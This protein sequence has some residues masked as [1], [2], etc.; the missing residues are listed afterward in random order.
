MRVIKIRF[1]ILIMILSLT[2][3]SSA[4][5]YFDI[6]SDINIVNNT[7]AFVEI[8]YEPEYINNIIAKYS[9]VELSKT[10]YPQ[11]TVRAIPVYLPS[12]LNN[13]VEI[14]D[15]RYT[16]IRNIEIQPIP[17]L[18]R[19]KD[20]IPD[21]KFEKNEKIYNTNSFYPVEFASFE[22]RGIFRNKNLGYIKIYP[23]TYNPVTK[24]ARKITKITVRLTFGSPPVFSSRKNTKEEL[25]I[26]HGSAINYQNALNWSTDDFIDYPKSTLQSSVLATGDFYQFDIK[27]TG[28]YKID[29]TLL[30]NAGIN[31]D[32][33]EPSTI[34][35]FNNG[36]RELPYNNSIPPPEDLIENRIFVQTNQVGKFDYLLFYG[37]SI[38]E[39][40]YD[41]V[42]KKF[43]NYY[44]HYTN[45][46]IYWL[47]FN[48]SSGKRMQVINSPNVAGIQPLYYFYDKFFEKPEILNLG[49][50]GTLWLSQN[51]SYNEGFTFTKQL[52]GYI[53]GSDIRLLLRFGNSSS[54]S[55]YS[56]LKDDNSS[57]LKFY[58]VYPVSGD[59]SHFRSYLV[60]EYYALNSG[61]SSI[62]LKLSLPAQY[63]QPNVK[64][65]YDFYEIH[66]RRSFNSVQ[67]N[68][69][70]FTSPDTNTTVEYVVSPYTASGIKVF[71]VTDNYNVS[72]INPISFSGGVLR[73][74]DNIEYN[75]PQR[76][77]SVS[78]ENYKT[79]NLTPGKIPNQ[80]LRGITQGASYIIITPTEFISAANR[81]KAYRETPG[82][83]K[84]NTL[85][86]DVNQIY[87]EFSCGVLD[88]VAIRN[89]IKHAYINWQEPPVYILFFGDGSYDFKNIYNFSV[90]NY[91]PTV[92]RSTEDINEIYSYPSDDFL[93]DINENNNEPEPAV[94]DFATGRLCINSINE[95]NI[96]VD[97]IIDYENS[98]TN[99]SWKKKLMYVA[100]DGWTTSSPNGEEGSMHTDQ[101]EVIAEIFTPKDFEKEK[102]YIVTYPTVITPQGRR[103]PGANV[104]IIKGW[105]DGRLVINYVGHGSTDLWAHEHVFVRD[106]SIP[107][108][109]NKNK[110]PLLTIASCDLSRWDDPFLISAGE[111]LVS[112]KDKGAISVVS[113]VRPVYSAPN[114]I[115]N[116]KLWEI[117]MFRKDTLNLPIRFG[118]AMYL[119]KNLIPNFSHN[120]A[121]FCLIGEPALRISIPQFF[122]RIDS[123]N[124]TP[125]T[126]TAYIKALQ[127][128]KISGSILRPDST[129]WSDFNGEMD[130]KV[131]D[132]DKKIDIID[133]SVHFI[134]TLDGGKIFSGKTNISNGKWHIEFIV[135]KDISYGSGSGKILAYFKDQINQGSGYNKRFVIN[136]IDSNAAI[137]TTGP[138]ITLFMDTRNFRSGDLVNQ[139]TKIIADFYDE[140]GINL[141]GT[142][143][144][145]IDGIINDEEN[146]KLDLTQ[147][148]NTTSGY[149]YGTLEYPLQNLID[150]KYTLKVKAWDTYNNPSET[151][152]I[153]QVKNN[154]ALFV[155]NVTN[156]P[157]PFKENTSFIFQH[158]FDSPL[159][160][161]IKIYTVGGKLIKEISRNNLLDKNVII[162]WDGRD[163]DGD[164]IANGVYLY[165]II[166]KTAD[167]G[168]TNS[169]IQKI[170]KL[171]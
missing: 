24:V 38:K 126:D 139:D 157:N 61:F 93:A 135:P 112:I 66:Y 119:T 91:L 169:S 166:I 17:G 97:K 7:N 4:Q 21:Y 22:Y 164:A 53:Q 120:D 83:N 162:E 168:F 154:T 89:F 43:K 11:V 31:V 2:K 36:G 47:N 85:V 13:R 78:G 92:Q 150:G 71:N 159:S 144:H 133:F 136:G 131:F 115:F 129:F 55:A 124:N 117:F 33:I 156:Y 46:N 96:A 82:I 19:P 130:L 102:I 59:F 6:F 29:R 20:N 50:T 80:N 27:E 116:N 152:I 32:N 109:T 146:N 87:N 37:L 62:N 81:L 127:K 1:L 57:F 140:S 64:G 49:S 100:D 160:A 171:K 25:S 148:Y 137:D 165:K 15:I 39:W 65:N 141:T 113:S 12:S 63:N 30:Q 5:E 106:E 26:F 94:P 138:E 143:G 56:Q 44:N 67:N 108:L 90:K 58:S 103:K 51:I 149:Q 68:Y 74:Q 77:I 125:Y 155:N 28:I 161:E 153:F 142:T 70:M 16:E 60:E 145:K 35:I 18:T 123:I 9:V 163:A 88:P 3:L 40:D 34:K 128:I 10:G 132:V 14:L 95:A 41:S 118:N 75:N 110:Y 54:V 134:F 107:Q 151:E 170:V 8:S 84:L 101:C 86:V 114:A 122:T 121:K 111:E 104:D 23:V 99:A 72:I 42:T 45:S 158:N 105:N 147:Y 98:I 79:P 167:G 52:P 76:Y 69:L 48:I 73:F